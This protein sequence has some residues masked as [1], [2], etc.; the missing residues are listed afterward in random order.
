ML[1]AALHPNIWAAAVVPALSAT[2]LRNEAV[3]QLL[4]SSSRGGRGAEGW[5]G[6]LFPVGRALLPQ[7]SAVLLFMV[8]LE[9]VCESLVGTVLGK[10]MH[11]PWW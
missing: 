2:L 8:T 7:Q 5:A 4:C 9:G 3:S 1:C 10:L 11:Y 6:F